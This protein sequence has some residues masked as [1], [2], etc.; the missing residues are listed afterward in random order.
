MR[1]LLARIARAL[2]RSP[3]PEEAPAARLDDV[4]RR[5]EL[6]LAALYGRP[7]PVAAAE[8][9]RR[10]RS[11]AAL[12]RR[13][14]RHLRPG[15]VLASTD[16]ERI[17][18]PAE[19]P[20]VDADEAAARYRVL[21]VGQ[22]ERLARGTAAYAPGAA[23][24]LE[25]DLYLLLESAAVDRAIVRVAPGLGPALVAERA[26][27]LARRPPPGVL[28]PAERAVEEVVRRVLSASPDEPPPELDL[29][30]T[31]AESLARAREMAARVS[32]R[33]AYRGVPAVAAWGTVA[34]GPGPMAAGSSD[35]PQEGAPSG[36]TA[37]EGDGG[38]LRPAEAGE[39][40]TPD[41]SG[42]AEEGTGEADTDS[43]PEADGAPRAS[44]APGAGGETGEGGEETSAGGERED[45]ALEDEPPVADGA[46]RKAK[47]GE[48][49]AETA[50]YPEWD[51]RAGVYRPDAATVH[52]AEAP[53]GDGAWPAEVLRQHGATVRRL[54]EKFERLRA[55]RLRLSRQR[56][57]DEL[58]LAACVAALADV[59]AGL[60]VDDRLYSATR[61][62][63]RGLAILLLVDISGS[64]S[65]EVEPGVRIIDLEKVALLLTAQALDA[66]GDP[67]AVLTFSGRGPHGVRMRA[68]K[69]FAER[70]GEAVRRRM[71]A[72]QPEGFTR[73]GAA[74]RHA[75]ARLARA[76]AG[77]RLL[78]VI[79]D[80]RPNDEDEYVGRYGVEDSRQAIA[81]ARRA[82]IFPFCLTVDRSGSAYLPRIFGT[83]GHEIVRQPAQ[84]PRALSRL[85]EHLLRK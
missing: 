45:A 23:T 79:S 1:V 51:G 42:Q 40:G 53:E 25:R 77:H 61:P 52:H 81:E 13:A 82:G 68:L 83:A 59:R 3:A 38:E 31:P 21:A 7:I 65:D 29:S 70:N 2:G 16:G 36:T 35:A 18:L 80:G 19:L 9:P 54:R 24:P 8:P 63:R 73:L 33:G 39:Q 15:A 62:A 85:V 32:G 75:T 49:R 43:G 78:L 44:T 47:P 5:L 72:L 34:A 66:L 69:D 37:E 74:V 41:T 17:L 6:L 71:G 14:P 56:D 4:R 12:L 84:L 55:R 48:A 10:R 20:G 57:G 22:A 50:S 58:D 11:L 60:P 26:A 27:A 30:A 64:T 28:T 46:P 67:Y 76:E